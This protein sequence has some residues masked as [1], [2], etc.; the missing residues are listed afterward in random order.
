MIHQAENKYNTQTQGRI[1]D[2]KKRGGGGHNTLFF[3]DRRQPR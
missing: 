2:L 1:Q 3:S